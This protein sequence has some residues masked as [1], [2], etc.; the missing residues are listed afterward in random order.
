MIGYG[1]EPNIDAERHLTVAELI[2]QLRDLIDEGKITEDSDVV[3]ADR[4][5]MGIEQWGLWDIEPLDGR[6]ESLRGNE[7]VMW[8]NHGMFAGTYFNGKDK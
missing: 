2:T 8:L 3:I 5:P 6:F 4:C 7:V 1:Y